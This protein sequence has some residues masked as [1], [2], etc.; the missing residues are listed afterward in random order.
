MCLAPLLIFYAFHTWGELVFFRAGGLNEISRGSGDRNLC[1]SGKGS[2]TGWLQLSRWQVVVYMKNSLSWWRAAWKSLRYITCCVFCNHCLFLDN[3]VFDVSWWS[4][5]LKSHINNQSRTLWFKMG[6]IFVRSIPQNSFFFLVGVSLRALMC[7][8]LEPSDILCYFHKPSYW[9]IERGK[10]LTCF[11]KFLAAL[12]WRATV[13][14]AR[15]K[16]LL[17]LV[18]DDVFP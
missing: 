9:I 11:Y 1:L 17:A 10:C 5:L 16:H 6:S 15:K 12:L 2:L 7:L 3:K 8:L 13:C 4:D 18:D 14:W